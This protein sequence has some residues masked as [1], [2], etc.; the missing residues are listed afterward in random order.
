MSEAQQ[1]PPIKPAVAVVKQTVVHSLRRR[2]VLLM[3]AGVL[4]VAAIQATIAYH[5]ALAQA[6]AVFDHQMKQLALVFRMSDQIRAADKGSEELDFVVQ[7]WGEDGRRLFQSSER[8]SVPVR[9][10]RGF[11]VVKSDRSTWR[12]FS[13]RNQ[14][15]YIQVAQDLSARAAQART[16][17]LKNAL[18][19]L[20]L[21]PLLMG[22]VWWAVTSSLAPVRQVRDQLEAREAAN[23]NPVSELGMPAEVR[24]LVQAFNSLL[25]RAGSVFE[26]QRQFVSNAAHELRT[27]LAALHLQLQNLRDA[28]PEID[29]DA[30]LTSLEQ[31][32]ARA[33]R[34]ID[35]LMALAREESTL[36]QDE[37]AGEVDLEQ[38]VRSA[39]AER[40]LAAERAELDLGV[41]ELEQ[42]T[43]RG[44]SEAIEILLGNLLDNAIKYTP[45]GGTVDVCVL[46]QDGRAILI[47]EDSG[48]GIEPDERERVLERFHRS[49]RPEATNLVPGSGLGLAIVNSIAARHGAELLLAKSPRLGGLRVSVSFIAV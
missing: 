1:E 24:P 18:P 8:R 48:P 5:S 10:G 3:L 15:Q 22:L 39:I 20:L 19:V 17:A 38:A 9:Q 4:V 13:V 37:A 12:V 41:T 25:V 11:S 28:G 45:A 26:S 43:I 44:W 2:L 46:R 36:S 23:L 32:V 31:G 27:P 6:D 33:S 49:E 47:V 21:V 30:A 16:M 7:V 29:R 42:L 40:A 14:G 34:L 35:Q